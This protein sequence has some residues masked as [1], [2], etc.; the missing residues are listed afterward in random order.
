M[1]IKVIMNLCVLITVF[2]LLLFL[3][4]EIVKNKYPAL[5]QAFPMEHLATLDCLQDYLTDDCIIVVVGSDNANVA[6]KI[7]LDCMISKL[8]CKEDLL[9]FFDQLEKIPGVDSL[10]FIVNDLRRGCY[11]FPKL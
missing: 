2:N 3:D 5:L 11:V 9:D 1:Q 4:L 10:R 7:M 8:T 6:N